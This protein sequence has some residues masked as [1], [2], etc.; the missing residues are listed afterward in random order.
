VVRW[1]GFRRLPVLGSQASEL[2]RVLGS[3]LGFLVWS[4]GRNWTSTGGPDPP[5]CMYCKVPVQRTGTLPTLQT[6][7]LA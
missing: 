2:V 6:G 5:V 1:L 7:Y 4:L 3:R